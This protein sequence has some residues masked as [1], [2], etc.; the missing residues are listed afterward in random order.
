MIKQFHLGQ[1]QPNNLWGQFFYL[2]LSCNHQFVVVEMF[3]TSSVYSPTINETSIFNLNIHFIMF[4][5]PNFAQHMIT[6]YTQRMLTE[7]M[8]G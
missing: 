4:F 6:T 2:S 1:L 5:I 7:V 8:V 3:C